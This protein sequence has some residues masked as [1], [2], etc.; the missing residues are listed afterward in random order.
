[1]RVCARVLQSLFEELVLSPPLLCVR[2]KPKLSDFLITAFILPTDPPCL[3][4]SPQEILGRMFSLKKEY[5]FLSFEIL[6][7]LLLFFQGCVYASHYI[8][9]AFLEL[10]K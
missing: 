2:I 9:L 7:C 4:L 1:M 3:H 6:Y 8:V 5:T 10:I